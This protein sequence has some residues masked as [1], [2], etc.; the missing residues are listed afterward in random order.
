MGSTIASFCLFL[1]AFYEVK[2]EGSDTTLIA[3]YFAF[4][5]LI[6]ILSWYM[7]FLRRQVY[8]HKH[9]LDSLKRKVVKSKLMEKKTNNQKPVQEVQEAVVPKSQ[10]KPQPQV[11]YELPPEIFEPTVVPPSNS[12]D[13][14]MGFSNE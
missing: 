14:T 4:T 9:N 5:L 8:V 11:R 13:I 7:G 2:Q 3:I 6:I 12:D 10:P 1:G